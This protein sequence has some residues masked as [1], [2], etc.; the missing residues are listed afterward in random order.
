M[1]DQPAKLAEQVLAQVA[2]L[3]N[4]IRTPS[5]SGYSTQDA[6]VEQSPYCLSRFLFLIGHI[7]IREMVYLDQ[8]IFKEL[9]RRNTV[10]D[11]KAEIKARLNDKR[12]RRKSM[13]VSL[14][15]VTSTVSNASLSSSIPGSAQRSIRRNKTEEDQEDGMEGATA[16]DADAEHINMVLE[17]EL[18]SESGYLRKFV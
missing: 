12:H 11:L 15:S 6:V 16:D 1:A 7:G 4:F 9:K 2:R 18:L 10:R 14:M 5:S 8:S 13:N 3:G 17:Q